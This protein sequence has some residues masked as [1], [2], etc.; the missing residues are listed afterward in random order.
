MLNKY[1]FHLGNLDKQSGKDQG[2]LGSPPSRN[3]EEGWNGRGGEG[4]EGESE[5]A[6]AER[7]D[8]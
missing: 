8:E 3:R 5:G 1:L 4:R 7:M 2:D 6:K